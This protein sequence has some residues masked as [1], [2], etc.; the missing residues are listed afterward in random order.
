MISRILHQL[1]LHP[2]VQDRL[3]EELREAR[4]CS[5]QDLDH[6]KLMGLPLLDAICKETLRL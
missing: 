6:D 1:A 3:R 2:D 4:D 5:D